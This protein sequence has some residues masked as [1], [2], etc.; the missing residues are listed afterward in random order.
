MPTCKVHALRF[1]V[2]VQTIAILGKTS[3]K[4]PDQTR[5]F[6][7]AVAIVNFNTD[8]FRLDCLLGPPQPMKAAI[9]TAFSPLAAFLLGVLAFP[10]LRYVAKAHSKP[11]DQAVNNGT[12]DI[13]DELC[14]AVMG[15]GPLHV[16][17]L[18]IL[19]AASWAQYLRL[20]SV[21]KPLRNGHSGSDVCDCLFMDAVA[22]MLAWLS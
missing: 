20:L 12:T 15:H 22:S 5:E 17:P 19:A 2:N 16:R 7:D 21:V 11:V 4:W 10:L 6:F 8:L 13:I 3:I 9:V 18:Q 14:K 1:C